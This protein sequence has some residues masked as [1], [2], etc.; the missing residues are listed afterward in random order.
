[1]SNHDYLE[2]H[3][4]RLNRVYAVL[5]NINKSIVRTQNQ[6]EL[7]KE[8]CQIAVKDGEYILA[9]IGKL[10]TI[11]NKVEIKAAE[12]IVEYTHN[13]NIDM[14]DEALSS[15]PSGKTLKAGKPFLSMD[16]ENDPKMIP[17]RAGAKKY[18]I[19]SSIALP[20]KTFGKV[21]G[22]LN[23]YS[24]TVGHFNKDELKLLIELAE[25]ISFKI[26]S[27]YTDNE[28]KKVE[29]KLRSTKE[30][31][32]L[33]LDST[34]QG[35][36]G[37]DMD[38]NCTFA[39]TACLKILGYEKQEELLGQHIHSLI[40]HTRPDGTPYP[41]T[42]C[43][44]YKAL[45]ETSG[46]HVTDEYF[47]KLDGTS[48]PVEYW[49]HPIIQDNKIIGAVATFFDIT[50]RKKAENEILQSNE[51]YNLVAK[52]TND[53]IWEY[54]ICSGEV[55]RS[56]DGFKILF[57]YDDANKSKL[58]WSNLI[59]PEDLMRVKKY[60]EEVFSNTH[61]HYWEDKYRFLKAN[62]DYA[63][64]YDR[65][66]IIRDNVGKAKRMIGATQDITK[67]VNQ[68]KAIEEQNKKLREIAWTQSHIVRAP[69]ARMIGLASLLDYENQIDEETNQ[70]LKYILSSAHELDNVIKSIV[71]STH[72]TA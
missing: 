16:I 58:H 32:R 24:G 49:S 23:L 62:G 65:G 34:A 4:R 47:W 68:I 10:N 66:Y 72:E 3:I 7:F 52:A 18:G 30:R 56:G 71:I 9:W 27:I 63:Y 31:I 14:R 70:L 44:M 25:N 13:V 33:L 26:E 35:I 45:H 19:R 12:G 60:Q 41:A 54:N 38:G 55:K 42:E 59:H 11:T 39:N 29:K 67:N 2:E 48:F 46:T 28:R 6:G 43:R 15:G 53:S 22:I 36:Y 57:G 5:S 8:V 64:V 37:I 50:E 40:H 20:L 61:Q 21:N 17:W 1:M 69:V 51:R